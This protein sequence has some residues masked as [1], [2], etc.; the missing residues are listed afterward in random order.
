MSANVVFTQ[1]IERPA[2]K[3]ILKRGFKAT[4]YFEYCEEVGCDIW[5]I[6]ESIKGALG[7][8]V[9]VWLPGCMRSPGTSEYCQAVEVSADYSGEIP[10]G[11]DIIDLPPCRYMVFHGEPYEEE[12]FREAI[13]LVW[14][15]ISRYDPKLFGW[16]WA[17]DDGP[18][19]QLAPIGERGYIEGLPVREHKR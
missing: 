3:L 14:D 5:G 19:F 17:P 9:G 18:R 12:N 10:Q 1:V 2:R 6:L 15:A 8:S 7:E 13:G 16:E 11:F 4:G